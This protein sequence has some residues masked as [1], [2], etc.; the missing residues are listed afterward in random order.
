[1]YLKLYRRIDTKDNFDFDK[2]MDYM[3]QKLKAK[4]LM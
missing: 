1:M 2:Q 4:M 3:H